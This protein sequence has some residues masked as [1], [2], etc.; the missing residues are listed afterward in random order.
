MRHERQ[1]FG[2]IFHHFNLMHTFTVDDN[3]AFPLHVAA[4]T[5]FAR[6]VEDAL[7]GVDLEI[8]E[9]AR[10]FGASPLRIIVDVLSR[11]AMPGFLRTFTVTLISLTGISAI[12]GIGGGAGDLAIRFGHYRYQTR[13][14]IITIIALVILVHLLQSA[15][16]VLARHPDKKGK[17]DAAPTCAIAA[18]RSKKV[19]GQSSKR[20]LKRLARLLG[21]HC[22]IRRNEISMRFDRLADD[23]GRI[24]S[25]K[26]SC[27]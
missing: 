8:I 22:H 4:I 10:A 12:A 1:M 25:G 16:D 2:M 15:G 23:S 13:V 7:C 24:S 18:S 26:R 17:N 3:A 5:F 20:R 14:M 19:F 21:T 11:E 6:I 9:A 27:C